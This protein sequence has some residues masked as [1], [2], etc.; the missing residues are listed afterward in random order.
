MA[1]CPD[2]SSWTSTISITWELIIKAQSWVSP[3]TSRF[4]QNPWVICVKVQ[5]WE[6][7]L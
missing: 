5:V 1:W 3:E 6:V 4:K 2:C 7:L